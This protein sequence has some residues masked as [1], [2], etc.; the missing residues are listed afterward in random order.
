MGDIASP[1]NVAG[2]TELQWLKADLHLHTAEDPLD[3]IVYD[4]EELLRNAARQGFRVIAIT[5]HKRVLVSESLNR[6]AFD[7]GILLIPS[8]E[9]RIDGCDVI[10]WNISPEEA[11]AIG[12]FDDLRELRR[13]RGRTMMTM[14]PHPYYVLGGSI[15]KRLLEEID[16]FD[17]IEYCHFHTK[18]FDPNRPAVRL[19]RDRALPLVATSDAHRLWAFGRFYSEIGVSLGPGTLPTVEQV[20]EAIRG[21]HIRM[22]SPPHTVMQL[23]MAFV[24]LFLEHPV[25]CI[26]NRRDRRANQPKS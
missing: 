16:C 2:S 24:F 25:R 5:L 9:L 7:L 4:A 10:V 22:T 26:L 8:V 12:S 20:F 23:L 21:G 6:L 17:A 3:A 11:D 13:H 14:A 18:W 19:A 15:G 1:V